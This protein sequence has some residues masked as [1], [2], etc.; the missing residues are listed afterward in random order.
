MIDTF[1]QS[2]QYVYNDRHRQTGTIHALGTTINTY[3]AVGNMVGKVDRAGRLTTYTYD[4]LNRQVQAEDWSGAVTKY[5]YDAVSNMLSQTDGRGNTSNYVYDGLNRRTQAIDSSGNQ[6][7]QSYV[8]K[9][10]RPPIISVVLTTDTGVSD[11][12]GITSSIGVSGKILRLKAEQSVFLLLSNGQELNISDAVTAD[13]TGSATWD[14]EKVMEKGI[15][16]L[17]DPS[18]HPKIATETARS[19]ILSFK[20]S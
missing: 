19:L 2:T 8:I 10:A 18:E 9:V 1:G 20:P 5:G 13:G 12:D 3:D 4:E 11:K 15:Q 6:T 7:T 16:E 17:G 14:L